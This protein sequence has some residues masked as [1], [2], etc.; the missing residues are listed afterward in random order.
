MARTTPPR[1]PAGPP[2]SAEEGAA[3]VT[4]AVV[5]IFDNGDGTGANW[6]L[7]VE[8]LFRSAFAM[9][10]SLPEDQRRAIALRVHEGS[11]RRMTDDTAGESEAGK[12]ES[13]GSVPAPSNAGVFKSTTPRPPKVGH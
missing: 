5:P 7:T 13:L 10:D 11:Y 12:T 6:R 8:S 2:G 4:A 9:L 3:R 1:K